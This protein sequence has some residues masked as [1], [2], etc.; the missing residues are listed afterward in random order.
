[1]SFPVPY[2]TVAF[3]CFLLALP[4]QGA[5]ALRLI[6]VGTFDEP[7]YVTAPPG[8]TSRV[9][10]VERA[11][12]IRVMIDGTTSARPFL[13]LRRR[14]SRPRGPGDERG[15]TSMAFAPDYATSGRFYVYYTVARRGKAGSSNVLVEEYRANP[16]GGVVADP[17]TRRR[18]LALQGGVQHFGGQ[19]A[20][21]PDGMLWIG[22]GDGFG[23]GDPKRNGQNRGQLRGK[24][25][26]VD[27]R[28]RRRLAAPGNPFSAR[29]GSR[30][31]WAYGLRNPYRFSFDRLT[32][33]LIIGD[34]GQNVVEEI[35]FVKRGSGWGRGANFGWSVLE[36]RYRFHQKAP[37]R[38]RPAR[39]RELPR[40]YT[41]PVIEHL[42][43]RGWC[44]IIGGYV[45]RDPALPSLAGHYVYGDFCRGRI[46]VA[47][48]RAGRRAAP[49]PT[50]FRVQLLSSFGE[51]GCGRV[52]VTSLTGPVYRLGDSGACGI[53][54]GAPALT[55]DPAATP[56]TTPGPS[57]STR[58]AADV[59]VPATPA[60]EWP[61]ATR[62]GDQSVLWAPTG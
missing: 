36:G 25:L 8:D 37:M 51:D 43:S 54:A 62:L 35:N 32:G 11:G 9:F 44:A 5:A 15:L 56:T 40:R 57:P 31:V 22:P 18:I 29:G 3:A 17:R 20:F 55:A 41:A 47:R 61:F 21:G 33:D 28:P 4:S 13:N 16:P 48:L 6:P 30:L 50:R 27:P 53:Q 59:S 45:V 23:P 1:V 7:V 2:R 34:V 14:V 52:Y 12:T 39:R 19:I 42:H 46:N 58:T 38:L 60:D 26:R 10:I 49:R 24:I